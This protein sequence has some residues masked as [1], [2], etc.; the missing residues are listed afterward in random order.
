MTTAAELFF[1]DTVEATTIM[2]A[3]T[4]TIMVTV[5]LAPQ[6]VCYIRQDI[7]VF[8]ELLWLTVKAAATVATG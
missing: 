6:M 8:T 7:L 2:V 1:T 3:S 4:V 5:L